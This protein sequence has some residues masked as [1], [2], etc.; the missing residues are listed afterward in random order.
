MSKLLVVY[1]FC[2][3]V[4][5]CTMAEVPQERMLTD[6]W[7]DSLWVSPDGNMAL[8]MYR[9]YN[10]FP[11]LLGKGQPVLRGADRSGHHNN[12][13]NVWEDSDLYIVIRS[14]DGR[15]G[16]PINM[17][18]NDGG[19][20]CCAMISGDDMYFQKGTDLYRS[21][22]MNEKWTRCSDR[23][24][25]TKTAYRFGYPFGFDCLRELLFGCNRQLFFA[26]ASAK[27]AHLFPRKFDYMGDE[28]FRSF[29]L[30]P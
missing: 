3:V 5:V 21:S 25:L 2:T 11:L 9:R 1:A 8:F 26:T 4:T 14:A 18:T 30:T 27:T 23:C 20:D 7:N 19:G 15:W 6:G 24:S 12:D 17:P 29:R 16:E 28:A 10:F 22:Y 13:L